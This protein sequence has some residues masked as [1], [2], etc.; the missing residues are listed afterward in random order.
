MVARDNFSNEVDPSP[1]SLKGNRGAYLAVAL[2]FDFAES[3][4]DLAVNY[5]I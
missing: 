3:A 5:F 2:P 1:V 4:F